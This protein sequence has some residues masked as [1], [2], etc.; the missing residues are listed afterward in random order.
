MSRK[1]F[2]A[3]AV[4]LLDCRPAMNAGREAWNTWTALVREMTQVCA[5]FNGG[6]KSD[7]FHT[8][9]GYDPQFDHKS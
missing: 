7:R 2:K 5:S 8:A 9:A 4:A 6:F 3:I 1:H